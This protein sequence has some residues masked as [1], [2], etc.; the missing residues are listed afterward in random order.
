M[1]ALLS[2]SATRICKALDPST[3]A[4]RAALSALTQ[5]EVEQLRVKHNLGSARRFVAACEFPLVIL[6]FA[7][8][9]LVF[10]FLARVTTYFVLETSLSIFWNSSALRTVA[11]IFS[12]T[13][14][15][16]TPALA[17]AYSLTQGWIHGIEDPVRLLERLQPLS[18]MPGRCAGMLG[19]VESIPACRAY[20]DTVV[21]HRE[22][23]VGDD[24]AVESLVRYVEAQ[25]AAQ[26]DARLLAQQEAVCRKL[27]GLAPLSVQSA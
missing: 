12:G 24:L 14:A 25:K 4:G 6:G 21:A 26:D 20:R 23:V 15:G 5:D 3:E 19:R 27:H 2:Q 13:V 18:N 16:G 17:L 22:L 8:V 1:N 9:V 7:A 10:T 11:A